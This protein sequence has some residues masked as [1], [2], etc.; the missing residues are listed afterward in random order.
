M[1]QR[2]QTIYLLIAVVLSVIT[3]SS[4]IATVS[5][6]GLTVSRLYNLLYTDVMGAA[7]YNV[8]PLFLILLLAAA[9]SFYTIFIYKQ[10]MRQ[11]VLC[12]VAIMAYVA[13]YIALIVFSKMLAPDALNFQLSWTAAL[14][15]VSVIFCF[16]ARKAIIAD[17]KLVRAADRI[18]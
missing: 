4:Q 12:M 9:V 13:W 3:L 5:D 8:W 6:Q 14:P 1:I 11:A 10:R 2:K 17:E 18:R 16:M 7:H 15:A